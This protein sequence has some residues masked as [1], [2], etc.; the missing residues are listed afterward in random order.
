MTSV[1]GGTGAMVRMLAV[2]SFTISPKAIWEDHGKTRGDRLRPL[3]TDMT[4]GV[5]GDSVTYKGMRSGMALCGL[6]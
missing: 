3:M 6:S 5:L 4:A 2:V 1:L